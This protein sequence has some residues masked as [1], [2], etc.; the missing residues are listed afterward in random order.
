M[1]TGIEFI[2]AERQRQIDKEGYSSGHDDEHDEGEISIAAAC[3][4]ARET[5]YVM[6]KSS[7]RI[8]FGDPW[9]WVHHW[10]TG[11]SMDDRDRPIHGTQQIQKKGKSRKRQLIIAGALIAAEIDRLNR[12]KPID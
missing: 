4:A 6:R 7:D 8:V 9:P 10:D 11:R 12:I 5:I 2:A 1:K 3:Y